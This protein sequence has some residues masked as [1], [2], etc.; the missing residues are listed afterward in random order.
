M[1]KHSL[2]RNVPLVDCYCLGS[3]FAA[4]IHQHKYRWA[5]FFRGY[6]TTA[7]DSTE[8]CSIS[9]ILFSNSDDISVPVLASSPLSMILS[10]EMANTQ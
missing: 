3:V 8:K 10:L 5:L 9:R 7:L 2:R 1:R 6:Y 4:I